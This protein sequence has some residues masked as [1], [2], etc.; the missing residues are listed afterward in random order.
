M[1]K[2]YFLIIFIVAILFFSIGFFVKHYGNLLFDSK[3][4]TNEN[5]SIN[6]SDLDINSLI[7]INNEE[8]IIN[9]RNSLIDFIW[10]K[11]GFPKNKMPDTIENNI[12]DSRYNDLKNLKQIDKIVI[13][14]DYEIN[15]IIYHFIPEQSN[16]ILIIYLFIFMEYF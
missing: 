11:Q 1:K 12:L 16:N 5:N 4:V 9:K 10:N 7:G 6:F 8:D 13:S 3:L 2:T 14:M 15:S